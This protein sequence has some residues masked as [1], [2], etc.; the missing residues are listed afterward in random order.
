M[1]SDS[2]GLTP[3]ECAILDTIDAPLSDN[4]TRRFISTKIRSTKQLI[5]FLCLL[6]I[7]Q[8]GDRERVRVCDV[9]EHYNAMTGA[10]LS[11]NQ[12]NRHL[13]RLRDIGLVKT[14][15]VG[16]RDRGH[17]WRPSPFGRKLACRWMTIW[18]VA[19]G[20]DEDLAAQ[21]ASESHS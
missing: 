10:E 15:A 9:T 3:L 19:L 6:R 8:E 14:K 13:A 5:V 16:G 11:H 18:A 4:D 21:I 7:D 2:T 20:L 12:V 17:D 1:V